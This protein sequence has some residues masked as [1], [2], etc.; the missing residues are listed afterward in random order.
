M[1]PEELNKICHMAKIKISNDELNK[2]SED[3]QEL[4]SYFSILD[5]I[6]IEESPINRNRDSENC[7]L[8]DDI[9]IKNNNFPLSSKHLKENKLI[10]P[11]VLE[12]LNHE[13]L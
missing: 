2:F 6:N 3:F 13:D 10:L 9:E 4:L 7:N 5:E 1:S 12:K 11:S 8:R